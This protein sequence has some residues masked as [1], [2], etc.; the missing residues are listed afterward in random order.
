M[1]ILNNLQE[2]IDVMSEQVVNSSEDMEAVKMKQTEILK[3][4]IATGNFIRWALQHII[5]PHMNNQ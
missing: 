1:N 2:Q 3:Q 5:Y 4:I